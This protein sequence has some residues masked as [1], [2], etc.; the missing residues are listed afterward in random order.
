M[1]SFLW[2]AS[3]SPITPKGDIARVTGDPRC[4]HASVFRWQSLVIAIAPAGQERGDVHDATAVDVPVR[5]EHILELLDHSR[6]K[7]NDRTVYEGDAVYLDSAKAFFGVWTPRDWPSFRAL[8]H[9]ASVRRFR[10]LSLLRLRRERLA[11]VPEAPAQP[12]VRGI[13]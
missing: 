6:R 12:H 13:T 5:R 2:A 4:A 8:F 1:P 10:R 7:C 3:R 9:D 11:R